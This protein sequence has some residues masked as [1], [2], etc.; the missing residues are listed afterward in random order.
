MVKL[1]KNLKVLLIIEIILGILTASFAALFVGIMATD[2]PSATL[3][4]GIGIG[5]CVFL[6]TFLPL[7]LLP[8]LSIRELNEYD[9]NGTITINIVNSIFVFLYFFPFGVLNIYFV[10]KIDF[11][12]KSDVPDS[13]TGTFASTY[14]KIFALI[15]IA[16]FVFLPILTKYLEKESSV[17]L[18]CDKEKI[19]TK[20][21]SSTKLYF[22]DKS[23][24][25]LHKNNYSH[26][27]V[28]DDKTIIIHNPY[29]LDK[30]KKCIERSGA[31]YAIKF[32]K[33]F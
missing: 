6:V 32:D 19:F 7:V 23:F 21:R 24:L 2:S 29:I 20:N 11:M 13:S 12:K 16:L 10:Y 9:R 3:L 22:A 5:F 14:I 30:A 4:H 25:S 28:L 27:G 18:D 15:F 17:I 26:L 31:S 33:K 1:T 8:L